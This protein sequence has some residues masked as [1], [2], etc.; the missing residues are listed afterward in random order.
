V[1]DDS[2]EIYERLRLRDLLTHATD[3]RLTSNVIP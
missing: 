1:Y 2:Y 3:L